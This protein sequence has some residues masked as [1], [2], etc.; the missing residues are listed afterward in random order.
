MDFVKGRTLE[1]G[2]PV[3]VYKNLNRDCFSIQDKKTKLVVAYADTVTVR[4]ANFV[5]S[6][7]GRQRAIRDNRRNVHAYVQGEFFISD[8]DIPLEAVKVG[9]YNPFKTDKF[10]NEDTNEVIEQSYLV[11]CQESRV[12][13]V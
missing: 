4:N 2:Q 9:Y 10:I 6:E 7:A 8:Q 11:H 12:H 1:N 13:Y 3:Q 5:I